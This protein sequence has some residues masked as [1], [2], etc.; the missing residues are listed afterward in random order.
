MQC[1]NVETASEQPS[2]GGMSTSRRLG[3]DVMRAAGRW[4]ICRSSMERLGMRRVESRTERML[5]IFAEP[6]KWFRTA[7]PSES[8]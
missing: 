3:R 7:N 5:A 4:N 8:V 2:C 6:R 1:R